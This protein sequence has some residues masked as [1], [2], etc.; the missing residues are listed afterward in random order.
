MST[1]VSVGNALQSFTRLLEGISR[2]AAQLP[3]PVVV[4]HGHTSFSAHACQLV[5]F[6]GMDEFIRHIHGADLLIMHAGA[7]SVIHAI[8]AG[9]VPVVMPRRAAFGEHVNDHQ[10]ELAQALAETGKVIVADGPD[11]LARVVEEAMASQKRTQE[12]LDGAGE[13]STPPLV[14]IIERLLSD[15]ADQLSSG[16]F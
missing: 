7:G 8:E 10:I 12:K 6:L 5:P 2:I 16:H 15:Y 11:D 4:Q 3:Q 13:I 1:F 14:S 9:K